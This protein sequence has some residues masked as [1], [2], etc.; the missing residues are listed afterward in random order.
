M[1][2]EDPAWAEQFQQS[3][4]RGENFPNWNSD[5]LR[6]IVPDAK[7]REQLIGEIRP[8][9]LNFFLEPIPVFREWP[10]APC[11]YIRFSAP[12]VQPSKYAQQA[13]WPTYELEAG[14]FH[15]LVDVS[16]V[17]NMIVEAADRLV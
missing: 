8:R 14:H 12:Y 10:D 16:A 13:G 4:E 11:I 7:L 5:D 1:K 2:S 3:L 15:M 17:T 9:G 6:E